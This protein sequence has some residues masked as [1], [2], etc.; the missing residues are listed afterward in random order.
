MLVALILLSSAL[1][2]NECINEEEKA[3]QNKNT[4]RQLGVDIQNASDYLTSE[5]R[6]FAVTH[7]ISHLYNYWNEIYI[8]KTRDNAI[9]RFEKESPAEEEITFLKKAKEYSDTLVNTE[10]HS[11]KLV[12]L[13]EGWTAENFKYDDTLYSYVSKIMEYDIS[14]TENPSEMKEKA[15]LMLYDEN[16]DYYKTNITNSIGTFQTLMNSR[17]DDDVAKAKNGTQTATVILVISAGFTMLAI[18]GILII[19]NKLYVKPVKNYTESIYKREDNKNSEFISDLNVNKLAVKV[20]PNGA[21]EVKELGTVLNKLI[22]A[23]HSELSQRRKTEENMRSERNRAELSNRSKSVFIA[24]MSHEMRTSLN[25]VS[26]YS[27]LLSQTELTEKQNSYVE[28]IYYSADVLL[29]LVNDVLDYT[30]LE[31]GYMKIEN[32]DFDLLRLLAEVYSIMKNQADMKNI[33]LTFNQDASLPRLLV[34]DSLRLRQVL[35]NLVSNAIKFTK[36]GGVTVNIK[37]TG[38]DGNKCTIY[39]EVCDTGTG[40]EEKAL[41]S[42]FQPYVQSGGTASERFGGTGLG[43]PICQQII[44]TMSNGK[45]EIKVKSK[46]GKGSVFYFSLEFPISSKK[47]LEDTVVSKPSYKN[48]KVLVTDDNEV[49]V[50]IHSEILANCGLD[51]FSA[52]SGKDALKILQ[53]ENDIKLIFMDIRMPDMDGFETA[54]KIRQLEK[55]KDTPIIALTADSISDTEGEF[56]KSGITDYLPKPFKVTRLYSVLKKYLPNSENQAIIKYEQKTKDDIFDCS[57]CCENLGLKHSDFCGIL[58]GFVDVNSGDCKKIKD[59]IAEKDFKSAETLAH[60]LK[61]ISGSIGCNKLSISSKVLMEQLKNHSY[62]ELANF[63]DIF[64]K[65]ISTI[66][67]YLKSQITENK[68][69]ITIPQDFDKVKL[70]TQIKELSEKNNIDA[71]E[72]FNK[73][74]DILKMTTDKETFDNLEKL[75]NSFDFKGIMVCIDK[76]LD[77]CTE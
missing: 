24:Q 18:G 28:G 49:N 32:N 54:Q 16:Y 71:I 25:A 47:V 63:E 1:Y 39:F 58:K 75:C 72:L 65:T 15:I 46:L 73:N 22:D 30:K 10:T 6:L 69:D 19:F 17:L 64:E 27:E 7:E 70:L 4:Y 42:V 57:Y 2:I 13:N 43:L 37:P 77:L 23:V 44:T 56:E 60:G 11:M 61:G 5:V 74:R 76:E 68:A 26:G 59:F 41:K 45:S 50:Q 34:G 8:T 3:N 48:E 12:M 29:E 62:D 21:K 66:K 14:D 38:F 51:V 40:I 9:E 31:S 35:I 36:Q 53:K 33:Y 52:Y 20:I 55:Y 67:K